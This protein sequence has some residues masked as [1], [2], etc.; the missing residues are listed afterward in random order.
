MLKKIL[1]M[2]ARIKFV[3]ALGLVLAAGISHAQ[4]PGYKSIFKNPPTESSHSALRFY[5]GLIT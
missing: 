2:K 1:E 3:I 4:V 5:S